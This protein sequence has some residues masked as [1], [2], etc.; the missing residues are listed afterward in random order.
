LLTHRC[1]SRLERE[2]RPSGAAA[3]AQR[4]SVLTDRIADGVP[5]SVLTR[6]PP[7]PVTKPGVPLCGVD[8]RQQGG[9][10]ATTL[11]FQEVH[12]SDSESDRKS[13]LECLRLASDLMEMATQTLNPDLKAHCL[14]MARAWTDQVEREPER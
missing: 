12:M 5:L 14:R 11:L 13:D 8:H 1:N 7:F 10:C 9:W 2:A 6:E 3:V 4:L